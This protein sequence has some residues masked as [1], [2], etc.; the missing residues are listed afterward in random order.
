MCKD[1]MTS[2]FIYLV[3]L[4]SL[5]LL[6]QRFWDLLLKIN[7]K[8]AL[9]KVSLPYQKKIKTA[10]GLQ[11]GISE[12]E[13][14]LT[15]GKQSKNVLL[16]LGEYKFFNQLIV[17]LLD[18]Q[19][20][21]GVNLKH[22]LPEIRR[23]L[24]KD[25]EFEK[26]MNSQTNG[27]QLQFLVISAVTWSFIFFSSLLIEI[28]LSFLMS[29]F[30]I[31][32]Q[33]LGIFT[34][35]I[36]GSKYKK[37]VFNKFDQLIGSYY[38]FITLSEMSF[39]LSETLKRSGILKEGL[40]KHKSFWTYAKRIEYLINRWKSSGIGPKEEA[41]EILAEIWSLKEENFRNYLKA[42]EVIKFIIL[43]FFFLPAYFLYLYSIFQFFM[44]H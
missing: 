6:P 30:I 44:E 14:S 8:K 2:I 5:Y 42:Q 36:L 7:W 22:I 38:L 37:F 32:L 13:S 27:A 25:L 16:E 18:L 26:R 4:G 11:I 35:V 24:T 12:I 28:P 20:K 19:K 1:M 39:P 9:M 33:S 21:M 15:H 29:F 34:F 23:E 41:Q 10:E 31:L 17:D 3:A 40:Y 43:A